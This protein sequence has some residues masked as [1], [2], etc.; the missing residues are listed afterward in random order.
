MRHFLS[1]VLGLLLLVVGVAVMAWVVQPG[2]VTTSLSVADDIA[3]N[4]ALDRVTFECRY[5]TEE[6][7]M[8]AARKVQARIE[9]T[10]TC[11]SDADC[12]LESFGCPFECLS[13]VRL[14]HVAE[15]RDTVTDFRADSCIQCANMC[16]SNAPG[17]RARCVEHRC[18]VDAAEWQ[19]V[20]PFEDLYVPT[21]AS[22]SKGFE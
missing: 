22:P 13:A 10:T 21:V 6:R 7:W 1:L 16:R 2:P 3:P 12:T 17:T 20:V 8:A 18:V 14:D 4:V 15:L 5:A 19:F 11:S 9:A